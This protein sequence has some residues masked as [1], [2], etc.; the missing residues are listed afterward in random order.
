MFIKLIRA[1]VFSLRSMLK[2]DNSGGAVVAF[3]NIAMP[4]YEKKHEVLIS[5]ILANNTNKTAPPVGFLSASKPDS[6][7]GS[8][9]IVENLLLIN[10]II[11]I[12]SQLKDN[13][14]VKGQLRPV[15][16]A[17]T[18]PPSTPHL[19]I[20]FENGVKE[21]TQKEGGKRLATSTAVDQT[22]ANLGVNNKYPTAMKAS[23]PLAPAST[24]EDHKRQFPSSGSIKGGSS[25]SFPK[26]R[27]RDAPSVDLTA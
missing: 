24:P 4:L 6:T 22:L 20:P 19:R 3:L 25:E 8:Q 10:N 27:R 17:P 7:E 9:E 21:S 12:R 16:T 26:R 11:V 2:V 13:L 15:P 14:L 1:N 23:R 18:G 5:R